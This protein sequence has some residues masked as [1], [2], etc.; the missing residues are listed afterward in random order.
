[1]IGLD[2]LN[3]DFCVSELNRIVERHPRG[4][5]DQRL[6]PLRKDYLEKILVG[7]LLAV[8]PDEVAVP[9]LASLYISLARF[10]PNAATIAEDIARHFDPD[11]PAMDPDDW[12]ASW[13]AAA[14][15]NR[16]ANE[17][18]AAETARLE[19]RL[20]DLGFLPAVR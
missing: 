11:S 3:P 12:M 20:R 13:Q 18:V 16:R 19:G 5:L 1:M 8:R 14:D 4:L 15:A 2:I 7:R 6:L 9:H 17:C 10:I